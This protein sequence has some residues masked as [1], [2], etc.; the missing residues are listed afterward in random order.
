M[1]TLHG[2]ATGGK[3]IGGKVIGGQVVEGLRIGGHR[4]GHRVTPIKQQWWA[5]CTCGWESKQARLK[6][7]QDLVEAHKW[8]CS[9]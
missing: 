1:I 8:S 3:V 4:V 2:H 5:T 7:V 9:G 6:S